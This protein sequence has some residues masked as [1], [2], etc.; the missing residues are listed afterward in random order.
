[1]SLL[2]C[3]LKM[4]DEE[5]P[6][7]GRAR[8]T[9]AKRLCSKAKAIQMGWRNNL[10][11]CQR[12]GPSSFLSPKNLITVTGQGLLGV[13]HDPLFQMGVFV[14]TTFFPLHLHIAHFQAD[15]FSFSWP[16]GAPLDC[17]RALSRFLSRFLSWRMW[18]HGTLRL[19]LL[20]EVNI[21]TTCGR[22]EAYRYLGGWKDKFAFLFQHSPLSLM[23]EYLL[24]QHPGMSWLSYKFFP[25]W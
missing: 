24:L 3:L 12:R 17:W 5:V 20:G 11:Y 9:T 4:R 8:R 14:V 19:L 6:P 13:S 2:I 22:K 16:Q 21:C 18:L 25:Y 15:S 23:A 10:F 7:Q 1:M